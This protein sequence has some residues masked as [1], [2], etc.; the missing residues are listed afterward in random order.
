VAEQVDQAFIVAG[1]TDAADGGR[2]HRCA[3]CFDR[4]EHDLAVRVAGGTKE[5]PR[6][7][8][9]PG[10]DQ[11]IGHS[12]LQD[13]VP[14]IPAQAGIQWGATG[15]PPSRGRAEILPAIIGLSQPPCRAR[16][17]ST[18]SPGFSAVSGQAARGTTAPL[19]ATAIPFCS[20]STALSA[21]KAASV[22]AAKGSVSPLTRIDAWLAT[23]ASLLAVPA[24]TRPRAPAESA[25]D[26]TA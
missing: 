9:L 5:K 18:E 12:V 3:A 22:A 26:R 7:E 1:K 25:R 11:R 14:L 20:V 6:A 23:D 17:I 16:T 8:F 10:N 19:S 2:H 15:S 13:S 24:L 4:V 21:S